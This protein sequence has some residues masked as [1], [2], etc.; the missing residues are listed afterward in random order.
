MTWTVGTETVS[1]SHIQFEMA[2]AAPQGIEIA[3]AKNFCHFNAREGSPAA[4]FHEIFEI[5]NFA[6]DLDPAKSGV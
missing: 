3:S 1:T 4:R 2:A 6:S 5:S